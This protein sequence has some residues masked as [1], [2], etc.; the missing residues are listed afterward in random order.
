M[1]R[2]WVGHSNSVARGRNV[3]QE[4]HKDR[5]KYRSVV[6][7]ENFTLFSGLVLHVQKGRERSRWVFERQ[8]KEKWKRV[9]TVLKIHVCVRT[10]FWKKSPITHVLVGS[11][12][13]AP[14]W[15]WPKPSTEIAEVLLWKNCIN[16]YITVSLEDPGLR[17]EVFYS[18]F[19]P[20]ILLIWYLTR[21]RSSWN[22]SHAASLCT[23]WFAANHRGL[24]Q[25]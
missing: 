22:L 19:V 20:C 11:G 1:W 6:R 13:R 4:Y 21:F 10:M 23:L 16:A 8:R 18:I 24:E 15:A 12:Q 25:S 9:Q 2:N 14:N 7:S 17:L 3:R 5:R